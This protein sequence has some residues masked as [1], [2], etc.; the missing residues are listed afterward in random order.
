MSYLSKRIIQNT[1]IP[2]VIQR[3]RLNYFYLLDAIKSLSGVT[4]FFPGL[5]KG[6]CP[7]TLPILV[8]G[9]PNFHLNLRARG[10]PVVT[11]GEVIHPSLPR[12][13]F[14]NADYLYQNLIS[15]PIHQSLDNADMQTTFDILAEALY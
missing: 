9:R 13:E 12:E 1:D 3:R 6:V 10:L 5:P 11:W 8:K 2:S 14:S 4:P 15:L 7:L